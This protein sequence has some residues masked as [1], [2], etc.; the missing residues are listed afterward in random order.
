MYLLFKSSINA[1][2]KAE[3]LRFLLWTKYKTPPI[4]SEYSCMPM[5][6]KRKFNMRYPKG[7]WYRIRNKMKIGKPTETLL[8][9]VF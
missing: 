1:K 8:Q 5:N 6:G 7:V 9:L 3:N 2:C 4:K